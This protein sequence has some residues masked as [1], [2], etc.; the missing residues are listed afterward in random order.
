VETK[1]ATLLIVAMP[2]IA[3]VAEYFSEQLLH[4]HFKNILISAVNVSGSQTKAE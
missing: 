1:I 2:L 4:Q 3:P